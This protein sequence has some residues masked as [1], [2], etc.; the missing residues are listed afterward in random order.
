MVAHVSVIDFSFPHLSYWFHVSVAFRRFMYIFSVCNIDVRILIAYG[1]Y[2]SSLCSTILQDKQSSSSLLLTLL[3]WLMYMRFCHLL[4][5][6]FSCFVCAG[7]FLIRLILALI[8]WYIWAFAW[9][10]WSTLVTLLFWVCHLNRTVC[11]MLI[12]ISIFVYISSLHVRHWS[13]LRL[14][15]LL[16]YF[17]IHMT[18]SV[19]HFAISMVIS[20]RRLSCSLG[21]SKISCILI[22]NILDASCI[23]PLI[24]IKFPLLFS[25]LFNFPHLHCSFV[26]SLH[27]YHLCIGASSR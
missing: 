26:D 21:R 11:P 12:L 1:T 23:T 7:S 8:L 20:S 17:T 15:V 9:S 10:L 5:I 22:P 27:S 16:H 4:W 2:L 18:L 13:L 6:Y 19:I 24:V 3:V 25:S 14:V